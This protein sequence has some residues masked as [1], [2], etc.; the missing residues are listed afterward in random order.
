MRLI[1]KVLRQH[2]SISQLFG[3]LMA[4]II[5]LAIIVIGLQ[6]YR[7]VQ[8]LMTDK[9]GFMNPDFMVISKPV[10][11]VF[12]KPVFTAEE[13]ADI[14]S[15]DF[16]AKTGVF[17]PAKY[18]VYLVSSHFETYMFF[19]SVPED[20]IDV[21]SEDW[22]FNPGDNVL[23]IILPRAYLNL[24]NF[25]FAPT[26]SMFP[27]ISE[28]MISDIVLDLRLGEAPDELQVKGRVVGLSSRLNTILVP[29]SFMDWSNELLAP[30]KENEGYSRIIVQVT[31]PTDKRIASYF[32]KHGFMVEG[33]KLDASKA[34]WLM[35]LL[36]AAVMLI[37]LIICA[38]ACYV[39]VL[40]IF[41]LMQRNQEAIRNLRGIGYT[42]A[43]VSIPY[44]LVVL[45]T[46]VLSVLTAM[47]IL[48]IVRGIYVNYILEIAPTYQPASIAMV[49]IIVILFGLVMTAINAVL[50]RRSVNKTC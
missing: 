36:V 39:L 50:I 11:N 19:E 22:V 4:N 38:L 40:S 35:R 27:A 1:W 12:E 24:Y 8:P 7:D 15:Q 46:N 2:I 28:S 25:G 45:I 9:E 48:Y 5:G 42:V 18:S 37:G 49:W 29:Q 6:L 14:E 20:F 44:R 23:P 34:G 43:K 30:E 26:A 33:D 16:V 31:N 13:I 32:E 17:T 47:T 10:E 21:N 41:L 3:F